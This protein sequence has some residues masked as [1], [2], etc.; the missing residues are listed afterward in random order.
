MLENTLHSTDFKICIVLE[1]VRNMF[2]S[3]CKE[4]QQ[5]QQQSS[6]NHKIMNML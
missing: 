6:T 2:M 3:Q 4:Q 1:I 5:Q